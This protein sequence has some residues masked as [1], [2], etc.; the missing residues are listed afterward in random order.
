M[1]VFD[2]AWPV[3]VRG[4]LRLGYGADDIAIRL[5]CSPDEVRRYIDMPDQ[6]GHIW[7]G[8]YATAHAGAYFA[9][10]VRRRALEEAAETAGWY[11]DGASAARNIRAMIASPSQR[12]PLDEENRK[13]RRLVQN[14]VDD[15]PMEPISDAGHIMLDL[16]R[17]DASALLA[18]PP[19]PAALRPITMQDVRLRAGEGTLGDE[20]VLAAVNAE[21]AARRRAT[22]PQPMPSARV[23]KRT[24]NF[25]FEGGILAIR[26]S[27]HDERDG[28]GY[29]QIDEADVEWLPHDEA[30]GSYLKVELRHSEVL[31]LRDYLN[32]AMSQPAPTV[33]EAALTAAEQRS[34]GDRCPCRGQDDYCGCQNVPDRMTRKARA[35]SESTSTEGESE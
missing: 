31:A 2:P 27:G 22:P 13:L 21:L 26:R 20:T 14:M 24:A 12:L 11:A 34:Q 29:F 6:Y 10:D 18:H 33:Q 28:S 5:G 8:E 17:H 16:W 32:E 1:N 7:E 23:G 35:L 19:Q 25:V 30:E 4:N 9:G 15:D 3:A